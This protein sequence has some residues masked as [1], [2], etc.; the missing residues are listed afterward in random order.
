MKSLLMLVCGFALFALGD[1]AYTI[2]LTDTVM[3]GWAP[4]ALFTFAPVIGYV[5]GRWMGNAK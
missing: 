1:I 3:G 2:C 5:L 4:F